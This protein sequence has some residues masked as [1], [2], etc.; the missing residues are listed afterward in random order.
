[1]CIRDR[2]KGPGSE[3]DEIVEV[4]PVG[5]PL[6]LDHPPPRK[7][8]DEGAPRDVYITK[9][10][11]VKFGYTA[12][13]IKC[14]GMR[15]GFKVNRAHSSICRDR[16]L[17]ALEGDDEYKETLEKN[18]EKK[19]WY[20]ARAIEDSDREAKRRRKQ[21]ERLATPSTSSVSYTHLTLPT[22][23]SV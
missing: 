6:D 22:I 23:C 2:G 4:I 20:I 17:K 5:L 11:I 10:H 14:R 1:M 16:I 19:R 7:P 8:R 13:C 12:T 15:E 9:E 3:D 18:D 21:E